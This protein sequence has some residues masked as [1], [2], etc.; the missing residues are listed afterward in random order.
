MSDITVKYISRNGYYNTFRKSNFAHDS[1][2]KKL[3]LTQIRNIETGC[4]DFMKANN[5]AAFS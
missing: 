4:R 2:K 5:Y 3:G 1:W